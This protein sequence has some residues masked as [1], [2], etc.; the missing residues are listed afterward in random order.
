MSTGAQIRTVIVDDETPARRLIRSLL[1]RHARPVVVGEAED[2]SSAVDVI[3]RER[4][5]LVFLDVQMPGGSGFDVLAAIG[6]ESMPMVIFATAYDRYAL[7]AFRVS[8]CDYLLKPFDDQRFDE[9]VEKV[10]KRFDQPTNV[11][12]DA[13]RMLLQQTAARSSQVV[14]KVD[15]RHIFYDAASIVWIEASDKEIRL[16]MTKSPIVVREGLTSIEQRIDPSTFVR[17]H[18]SAIVNRNHIREIQPWFRGEYVIVMSE[19]TKLTSGR[20]YQDAIRRLLQR[21]G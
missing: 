5:Q 15:G 17:V 11:A 4:P 19:G 18:R 14:V 20:H 16:H 9:A 1:E 21:P 3:E 2:F 10:V 6:A 13:L 12:A 7:D 8:A